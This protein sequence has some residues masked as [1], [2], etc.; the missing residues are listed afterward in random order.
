MTPPHASDLP[1]QDEY[2]V[3]WIL[4]NLPAAVR[5]SDESNRNDVLYQRGFPLGFVDQHNTPYLYNHIRFIIKYNHDDDT[6]S[7]ARIVGFEVEPF[8]Y[9]PEQ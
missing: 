6:G 4:D 1:C 2:T 3:H 7:L 8:R 5:L 9:I